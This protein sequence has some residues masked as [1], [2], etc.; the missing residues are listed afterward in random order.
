MESLD[1][2]GSYISLHL[3]KNRVILNIK[4]IFSSLSFWMC[5]PN[6]QFHKFSLSDIITSPLRCL[7]E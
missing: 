4:N 1:H 5:Q 7:T 3:S 6:P 2:D